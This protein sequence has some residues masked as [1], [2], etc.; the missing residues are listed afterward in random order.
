M[1]QTITKSRLY[2]SSCGQ[3]VI[4]KRYILLRLGNLHSESRHLRIVRLAAGACLEARHHFKY[5]QTNK[6]QTHITLV[7]EGCL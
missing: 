3:Y 5:Q 4:E 1:Q 6:D 2:C 7:L